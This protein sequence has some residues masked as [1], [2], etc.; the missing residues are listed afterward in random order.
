MIAEERSN[1]NSEYK[2]RGEHKNGF[3][4]KKNERKR[5]GGERVRNGVKRGRGGGVG[6]RRGRVSE[7]TVGL[8]PLTP[9]TR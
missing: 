3:M 6:G 8:A 2:V 5:S 7:F 9:L 1:E 4:S